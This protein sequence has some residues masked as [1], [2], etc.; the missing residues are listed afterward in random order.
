MV[1]LVSKDPYTTP[2]LLSDIS[3]K[4]HSTLHIFPFEIVQ[5]KLI[6]K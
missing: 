4:Q 1:D 2:S 6:Q 5:A 3:G